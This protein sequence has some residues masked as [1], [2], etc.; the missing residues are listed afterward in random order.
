V[1]ERLT[2]DVPQGR[3]E[4]LTFVAGLRCNAV[5]HPPAIDMS[6]TVIQKVVVVPI[7]FAGCMDGARI[8]WMS[9]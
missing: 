3:W 4:M 7:V 1:G 6:V 5:V 9:A 2:G 8:A